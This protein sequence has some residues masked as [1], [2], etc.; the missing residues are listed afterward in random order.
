MPNKLIWRGRLGTRRPRAH[1]VHVGK[2]AGTA[3]KWALV[4]AAKQG[5]YELCLHRHADGLAAMPV[6]DR[7]FFVVRD[8]I[9]RF[10]SGFLSRER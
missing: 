6:G 2:T 1:L 7:V 3:L 8:P 9:D 4:P 5:R 10:V